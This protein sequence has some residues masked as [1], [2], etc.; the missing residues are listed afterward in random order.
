[1]KVTSVQFSLLVRYGYKDRYAHRFEIDLVD[2]QLCLKTLP[3]EVIETIWFDGLFDPGPGQE[4]EPSRMDP[5]KLH[6]VL[7]LVDLRL[8]RNELAE[9]PRPQG[10][11]V[12]NGIELH[13]N[14]GPNP[15]CIY[16]GVIAEV[17]A[18]VHTIPTPP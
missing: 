11:F 1:M 5:R 8:T 13:L 16:T 7:Q 14:T 9:R 4:I 12:G 10:A 2:D 3:S 18:E 6:E 15:R 17:G